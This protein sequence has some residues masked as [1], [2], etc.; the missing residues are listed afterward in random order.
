MEAISLHSLALS[1]PFSHCSVLVSMRQAGLS[2][3]WLGNV[4]VHAIWLDNLQKNLQ[5]QIF[6]GIFS[7]LAYIKGIDLVYYENEFFVIIIFLSNKSHLLSY[8][9]DYCWKWLFNILQISMHDLNECPIFQ[10]PTVHYDLAFC[11][12]GLFYAH[13]HIYTNIRFLATRF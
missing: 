11:A 12:R 10:P 9:A 1:R 8:Q 2:I 4:N 6:M 7:T 13:C 5:K 3:S